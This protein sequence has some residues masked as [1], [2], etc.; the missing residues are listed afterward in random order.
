MEL[1]SDY[2]Q[3]RKAITLSSVLLLLWRAIG[4]ELPSEWEVGESSVRIASSSEIPYV[5][6][7]ILLFFLARMYIGCIGFS[8][9]DRLSRSLRLDVALTVAL[10]CVALGVF[11]IPE[12]SSAPQ[13]LKNCWEAGWQIAFIALLLLGAGRWIPPS[14]RRPISWFLWVMGLFFVAEL[15]FYAIRPEFSVIQVLGVASS[16]AGVLLIPIGFGQIFLGRQSGD[17]G[18]SEN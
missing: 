11:G 8:D 7:F 13:P 18:K 1:P 4:L 5:L 15:V 6:A 17:A 10:S 2:V 3:D 12:T 14:R 9:T 16:G